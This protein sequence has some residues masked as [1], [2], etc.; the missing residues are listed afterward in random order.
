MGMFPPDLLTGKIYPHSLVHHLK[1]LLKVHASD[2]LVLLHKFLKTFNLSG[3]LLQLRFT[4]TCPFCP[5]PPETVCHT[6]SEIAAPGVP[7]LAPA[8][9]A[10]EVTVSGDK[11]P[12]DLH[13]GATG[14][15]TLRPGP[16][17]PLA[18]DRD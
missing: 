4:R 13:A 9:S 17:T 18:I 12:A 11:S 7:S 1:L 5:L 15:R 16:G 3:Y 8:W 2:I 6:G 14:G 10:S